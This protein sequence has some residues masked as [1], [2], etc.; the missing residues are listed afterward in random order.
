M[1][2]EAAT[3]TSQADS[4]ESADEATSDDERKDEEQEAGDSDNQALAG[5]SQYVSAHASASAAISA[6]VSAGAKGE[7]LNEAQ[8]QLR[9]AE[10]KAANNDFWGALEKALEAE[11]KAR[12]AAG[13]R[14]D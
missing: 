12:E 11:K 8:E 7:D 14:E 4:T 13:E 1:I 2:E 9:E 6:A 3:D 5:Q 10:A